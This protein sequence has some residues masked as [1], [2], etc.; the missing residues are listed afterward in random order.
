MKLYHGSL[1][2]VKAPRILS[3]T[4]TLDYGSGFYTTT[5]SEQAER[6]IA[7]KKSQGISSGYI[8]IYTFSEALLQTDDLQVLIFNKPNSDWVDFVMQNRMN[9]RYNHSY[10]LV[11]GP[12]ANDKVYAAFA[13]YENNLLD[14]EGLI[15]ELKAYKLV[16]QILFHTEKALDYLAFIEAKE[17]Q[18]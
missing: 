15:R 5:S 14:K 12:V 17:I 16:D 6:W 3:P 11:Y 1:E 10:D 4:R 9:K 2:I 8:N 7:R 13:L 18:L